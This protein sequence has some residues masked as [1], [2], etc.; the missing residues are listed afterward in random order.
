MAFPRSVAVARLSLWV[1][2]EKRV[3]FARK[4][5]REWS[6]LLARHGLVDGQT[7]PRAEPA[8]VF[9]RLYALKSPAAIA[10]IREAL[11]NDA[12]LTDWICDLGKRYWGYDAEKSMQSI[13]LFGAYSVP[14]GAGQIERAGAGFQRDV[15]HSFGIHSGLST[16]IVHDVLQDRHRLLWVATQG[17]GIVRYD[18]YQFTTFTTRD[19]LSHDSVACALEDRRGRLW[20]GTGHWLELYGHGVC[21]YDGECFE[22]FSRADGLGHNEISALLEDDAGRVWLAT[23]MGLSCYEGGR[24]TT[25]YASDGLP[26]HT[27]YALFQDDQGVLWIGTR[28]GVCSYRD[29]V[30]TLLS[31]PC[32][33][34]EAP[35]QAIYADDRGHLWFGTGVVG[36]YGEGVYRYDGRKFEHF[37]TADGLAENAVTALLRDHHGRMWLGTDTCG[38][39]RYDG[40]RFPTFTTTDGLA[41]NQIRSIMDDGVGNLWIGTFGGGLC[42]YKGMNIVNYT[43]RDGL[44]SDGVMALCEDRQQRVWCG[45][46]AGACV[47]DKERFVAVEET[48]GENVRT[49]V[50]DREGGMWYGLHNIGLLHCSEGK[51]R[52]YE[53][54]DGVLGY[55]FNACL[56]DSCGRLWIATRFGLNCREDGKFTAYTHRDGLP[57]DL[58]SSL[59]EDRAGRIWCGTRAGLCR[60]EEGRFICVEGLPMGEVSALL[61]DLEGRVWVAI[62]R[63]GLCCCEGEHIALFTKKDG[64][65]HDEIRA[66]LQDRNGILWIATFGGGIALYDGLVWQTLSR[67]DGLAH[68]AVHALHQ[69]GEG[70]VWIATEG[71]VVRYRPRHFPP[72]VRLMGV[73]ADHRHSAGLEGHIESDARKALVFEFEGVDVGL[74]SDQLTY[75]YRMRGRDEAWQATALARVECEDLEPGTYEFEVRAVDQDMNYSDVATISVRLRSAPQD[76]HIDYQI[77]HQLHVDPIVAFIQQH[78]DQINFR[79]EVAE[80]MQ[81]SPNTVTNRLRS[82]VGERFA[83]FLHR[84]RIEEAKRLLADTPIPITQVAFRVGFST[85]QLFSRQFRKYSGQTPSKYRAQFRR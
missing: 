59:M 57:A 15:W 70:D 61:E 44:V 71:G 14:A 67:R 43:R 62:W 24:F 64:L 85:S 76:E 68:D 69:D 84:C 41:N 34:G 19:G 48:G 37:T 36:R 9:S 45:T 30:F 60:F 5:N 29:S 2:A 80:R 66:L 32:G 20:F 42:R 73:A 52:C 75:V 7:C 82:A 27:I 53:T 12:T 18:G 31:D 26:H 23:T 17:G 55:G 78:F 21:R 8:H 83:D 63:V 77:V 1:P 51:S 13:L 54:A 56:E 11:M 65:V 10:E 16:S 25:Y 47:W 46:W 58:V 49:M 22:T 40:H 50:Q 35:V 38:L 79:H 72:S 39:S 33:P 81:V 4:F 3:L 28:R 74:A 6:P